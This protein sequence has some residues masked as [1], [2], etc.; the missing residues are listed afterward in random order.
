MHKVKESGEGYT[1]SG[2]ALDP[3]SAA[4]R[5]YGFKE[6]TLTPLVAAPGGPEEGG[7]GPPGEEK[8]NDT[9]ATTSNLI[10]A[11]GEPEPSSKDA[12]KVPP[13]AKKVGG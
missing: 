2:K 9:E 1:L 3:H 12:K 4:A 7:E 13:A 5:A 6:S 10:A 11:E 8:E